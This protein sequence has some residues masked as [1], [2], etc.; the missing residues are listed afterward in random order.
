[1][2]QLIANKIRYVLYCWC[3]RVVV[4]WLGQKRCGRYQSNLVVERQF[5]HLW[6]AKPNATP[7]CKAELFG[8]PTGHVFNK[9]TFFVLFFLKIGN[10]HCFAISIVQQ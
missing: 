10:E 7:E 9:S 1:M 2:A 3:N 8:R 6:T 5:S 4:D